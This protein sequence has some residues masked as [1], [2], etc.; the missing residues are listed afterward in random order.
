MLAASAADFNDMSQQKLG[1]AIFGAGW[2]ATQHARAYQNCPR[3]ELVAIGSRREESARNL[4]D[5]CGADQALIFTDFEDILARDEVDIISITTPPELHPEL[6]I[7]AA[8]AGKHLCIE[9]PLALDWQSCLDVQKVAR[10]SGVKTLVSFVLHWNPALQN[11]RNLIEKGAIGRP[12]YIEV[13]YWHGKTKNRQGSSLLAAGGHAV[14]ALRWFA[15][16]ENEV[17][18]VFAHSIPRL[19]HDL[20]WDFE[21]TTVFLCKFADGTVGKV[22]SALDCIMPY[23]F[24]VDVLGTRGTIRDNRMWSEELFPGQT[25]WATIPT[26]LP[27]SGDVSYH[28]F[29]GQIEALV[30]AILDDVPCLPDVDDAVKTHQLIFAADLSARTGQPVRFASEK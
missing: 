3:T 30:A 2:V 5:G 10:E 29:D 24:N 13:D 1:A 27:D 22:S 25:D 4:A 28:P 26:V 23:S 7:R 15:G 11:V 20:N 14:D 6:A 8:R 18:E 12:Y 16:V 19:G 9:K 17:V 21:P